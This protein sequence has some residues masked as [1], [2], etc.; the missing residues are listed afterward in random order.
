MMEE[1]ITWAGD[2][3]SNHA[4]STA[5]LGSRN[6]QPFRI[7]CETCR[8]RLKIRSADVIGQI[9]ACPK[10]GSMVQVVAP[11]G[12]DLN[13]A[14]MPIDHPS[15]MSEA[16]LTLSTTASVILPAGVIDDP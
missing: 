7:T 3:E 12:W 2:W 15:A 9:Y 10:C 11:L 6:L 16:A 1:A 5:L 14:E 13:A 8:S 4:T